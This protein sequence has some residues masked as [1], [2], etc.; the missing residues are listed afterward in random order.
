MKIIELYKNNK[1]KFLDLFGSDFFSDI[2]SLALLLVSSLILLTMFLV[3]IFRI[4]SGDYLI[5]LVYNST[6]GVTA[7]GFWYKLYLYPISYAGFLI[8]NTLIA[9]AYFDRERLISY[10]VLLVTALSGLF[11]LIIEY[12]LTVLIKG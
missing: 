4:K 12:N 6:F 9:W 3:L 10:L 8:L 11:F 1:D 2:I 5:P 7:L